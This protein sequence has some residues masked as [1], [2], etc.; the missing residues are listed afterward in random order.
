MSQLAALTALTW[1]MLD[2]I[3][4]DHQADIR[5]VQKMGLIKLGLDSCLGVAEA[6]LV[7]GALSSL[8]EL[9]VDEDDNNIL[10]DEGDIMSIDEASEDVLEAEYAKAK[11]LGRVVFGHPSLIEVSG[12]WRIFSMDIPDKS[13]YWQLCSPPS[14]HRQV[15]RKIA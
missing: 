9:S 13:H 5:P 8:K 1:L 7:R 2:G 11:E 10:D 3:V 15:W 6:L 12:V 4:L 14:T